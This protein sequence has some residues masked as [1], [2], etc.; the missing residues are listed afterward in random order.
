MPVKGLFSKQQP[1]R[2]NMR[3]MEGHAFLIIPVLGVLHSSV[4]RTDQNPSVCPHFTL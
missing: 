2:D 4:A 1:T 3:V